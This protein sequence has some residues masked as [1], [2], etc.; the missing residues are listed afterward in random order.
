[1]IT[2]RTPSRQKRQT[3]DPVCFTS[4]DG[5]TW[6]STSPVQ[7]C[8]GQTWCRRRPGTSGRCAPGRGALREAAALYKRDALPPGDHPGGFHVPGPRRR[9]QRRHGSGSRSTAASSRTGAGT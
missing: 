6:S 4:S 3:S 2:K 1:M 7:R 9:P 8:T 5:E